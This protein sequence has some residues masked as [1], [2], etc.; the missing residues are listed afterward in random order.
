MLL[1]LLL[2]LLQ[3]LLLG[4]DKRDIKAPYPEKKK[5]TSKKK[6]IHRC[7]IHLYPTPIDWWR[8]PEVNLWTG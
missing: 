7:D 2:L 4:K 6:L 1:P 5:G 3:E 8:D